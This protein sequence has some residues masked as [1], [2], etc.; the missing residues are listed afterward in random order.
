M[1]TTVQY[2][3]YT[4]LL[5]STIPVIVVLGVLYRWSLGAGNTL[6][7]L[8]RMVAQLLLVG[9]VLVYIFRSDSPWIVLLVLSLMIAISS[10][11]ALRTVENRRR[12]L[13]LKAVVSVLIGGGSTLLLI[14]QGVLSLQPWYLPQYV[15]P[16]A[17]MVFAG[18]MNSVSLAAERLVAETERGLDYRGARHI[19]LNAALIPIT[20]SLF[21][22][23]LV[24]L[25][26][27][28]TGQILSGVS[29]MIAVNYQIMVMLMTFGSAGL[30]SVCFLIMVK[31]N[32][33]KR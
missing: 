31:N 21:A 25:P 11:I 22:V 16:L 8:G 19:A 26:G 24:A 2:I 5:L 32:F 20:N 1:N 33:N 4:K 18:V 7:A 12:G 28:M 30:S 13:Y 6:Y 14:T 17:G 27:M 3:P 10:W 15:I 29:P 23:G 9:Y